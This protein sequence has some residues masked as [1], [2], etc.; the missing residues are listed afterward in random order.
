MD[1]IFSDIHADIKALNSILE[2]VRTSQFEAE[3]GEISRIINLGDLLER[4][5]EP[6]EV[7]EKMKMLSKNYQLDSVMGNHDE[8]VLYDR[9]LAG[10]SLE[11]V[12]AHKNL[13]EKNFEFF[14]RNQDDTYGQQEFV[15]KNK[16]LICVHG[17]PLDPKKITPKEIGNDAWLYQKTWQRL[18]EDKET[19]S[20]Y[21]YQYSSSSAFSESKQH[22]QNPI[23]LCGHQHVEAAI[24]QNNE[25]EIQ[26]VLSNIKP[27]TDKIGNYTL[28]KKE[29]VIE[30]ENSYLIRL[31]IGGPQGHY[32]HGNEKPHFGI[33]QHDLKKI[34]LFGM[35][36]YS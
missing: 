22:I 10:S 9:N 34:I 20:Y 33:I 3:Y 28:D 17:G 5:T 30:P 35:K 12:K 4:G 19:F 1:L 13:T 11:S 32:G 8:A 36:H 29:I 24:S 15:D 7:L 23:I 27:K 26:N 31:G 16:G 25:G 2:I 18:T 6:G 21:G 14:R